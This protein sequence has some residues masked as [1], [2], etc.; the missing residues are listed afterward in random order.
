MTASKVIEEIKIAGRTVCGE[1]DL[2][3]T[4]LLPHQ[5]ALG[6]EIN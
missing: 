6:D 3:K 4:F 2:V 5:T 1:G